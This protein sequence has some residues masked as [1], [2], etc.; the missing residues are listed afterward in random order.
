MR[1]FNQVVITVTFILTWISVVAGQFDRGFDN[2]PPTMEIEVL[3][4]RVDSQ[5][6]PAVS[7]SNGEVDI[8]P[9]VMVHRYYYSGDRTFQGP[10]LP[11]GP[12]VLVFNHPKT[13]ARTYVPATMMPGAPEVT[14]TRKGITYRYTK[15]TI[16]LTFGIHGDPKIRYISGN[17]FR[18]KLKNVVQADELSEKFENFKIKSERNLGRLKT[19]L[20]GVGADLAEAS[21][22]VTLPVKNVVR[23]LPFGAQIT[24]GETE[25]YLAERAAE[26]EREAKNYYAEKQAL[27]DSL[28]IKTNR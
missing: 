14:Y 15:Q 9:V 13:G 3:D 19:S 16:A 21:K 5:G 8:P 10:M 4:P 18:Q 23:L 26:F 25:A 2:V 20:K 24:S 6:N 1:N 22:V 12:S 28:D 11:G 17:T 7:V 27:L